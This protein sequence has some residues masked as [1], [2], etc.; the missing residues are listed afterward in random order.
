M[1]KIKNFLPFLPWWY[2]ESKILGI[3]QEVSWRS[4]K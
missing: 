2:Q 4:K 1:K 3:V